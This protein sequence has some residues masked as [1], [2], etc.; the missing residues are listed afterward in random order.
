MNKLDRAYNVQVIDRLNNTTGWVTSGDA[1]SNLI[2]DPVYHLGEG[3]SISVDKIA[4]ATTDSIV[5]VNLNYPSFSI[6]NFVPDDRFQVSVY[7]ANIVSAQDVN[8]ILG[9]DASNYF[10]WR[11]STAVAAGWKTYNFEYTSD[12]NDVAGNG[13]DKRD[14]KAIGLRVDFAAPADQLLSIRFNTLIIRER[15]A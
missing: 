13:M 14:I 3:S 11:S 15:N 10:V 8:L 7:L 12:I 2:T 9:T 1:T 6:E 4:S 5:I